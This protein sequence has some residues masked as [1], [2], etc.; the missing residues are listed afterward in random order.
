MSIKE[1]IKAHIQPDLNMEEDLPFPTTHKTFPAHEIL[2]RYDQTEHNA[3]FLLEGIVK[4]SM[5][6]QDGQERILE[7]FFPG[8][9][10]SSYTSFL[11]QKPSDAQV[12]TITECE[13][14]IIKHSD[15]TK[16]YAH[17][18]LANKLGR[19]AAEHYYVMKTKREK[20]FLVKSA[21]ERYWEL[22]DAR[23]E[24][25]QLISVSQIARY[26][27]IEPESLSRIRKTRP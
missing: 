19:M 23:P 17:S 9:F 15:I 6:R 26:L 13:V 14:E 5:M 20:D 12:E 27:G 3:Y 22:V 8:S 10:F 2:T 1:F 7:F 21:S 24:I 11:T 18:L 16:A 4:I 25:A